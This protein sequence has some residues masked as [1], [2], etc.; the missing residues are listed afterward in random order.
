[1]TKEEFDRDPRYNGQPLATCDSCG[2]HVRPARRASRT[3]SG[4]A[5][6][7]STTP[8]LVAI[9]GLWPGET[10]EA[11][12]YPATLV[13]EAAQLRAGFASGTRRTVAIRSGTETT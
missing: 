13:A 7:C 8:N 9:C 1:M 6:R 11:F 2:R 10:R 12:G 5:C 3:A 4:A